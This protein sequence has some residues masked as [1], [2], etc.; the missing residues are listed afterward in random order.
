LFPAAISGI[1]IKI[2]I[3]GVIKDI[4]ACAAACRGDAV[5]ASGQPVSRP[6]R[7][8]VCPPVPRNAF[9]AILA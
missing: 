9:A 6:R 8:A 2:L 7:R 5:A 1:T 3:I 4:T